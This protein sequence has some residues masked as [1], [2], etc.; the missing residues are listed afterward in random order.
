MTL[1]KTGDF[2]SMKKQ[3]RF[4]VSL[5]SLIF[6]SAC[7]PILSPYHSQLVAEPDGVSLRLADAADRASTALETLASVEQARTPGTAITSI[8][9][10]PAALRRT[11]SVDWIGPIEPVAQRL[12]DRAGYKFQTLGEQPPVPIIVSLKVVQKPVIEVLR[13]LGLQSGRRADI[14]V[15]AQRRVV[16]IAYAP[17]TG[18]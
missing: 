9:D 12:A 4:L 1:L 13:D 8:P 3:T 11:V 10:A 5:F 18:G 16:E 14:V 17:V 6:V 7:S 15:D 2:C